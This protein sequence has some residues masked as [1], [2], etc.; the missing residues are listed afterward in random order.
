MAS[1]GV[2]WAKRRPGDSEGVKGSIGHPKLLVT[3]LV[4][5]RFFTANTNG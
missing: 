1:M 3:Q 5:N 2:S 4:A